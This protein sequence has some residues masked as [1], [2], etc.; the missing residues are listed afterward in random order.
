MQQGTFEE[1]E[2]WAAN[3]ENIWQ[4]Y[5]FSFIQKTP[6]NGVFFCYKKHQ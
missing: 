6:F 3:S 4:N 5:N 1:A 2:Q